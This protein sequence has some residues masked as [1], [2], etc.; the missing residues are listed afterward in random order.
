MILFHLP[1]KYE[2]SDALGAKY[3]IEG[4]RENVDG[5]LRLAYEGLQID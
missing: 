4:G 2:E 3:V 1:G 5:K